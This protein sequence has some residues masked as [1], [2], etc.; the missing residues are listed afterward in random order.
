MK[1]GVERR[2]ERSEYTKEDEEK[3]RKEG[4][5]EEKGR[6]RRKSRRA[7]KE[8]ENRDGSQEKL[9]AQSEEESHCSRHRKPGITRVGSDAEW[10]FHMD[11]HLGENHSRIHTVAD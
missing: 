2:E 9:R 8:L 5:K 6:E 1:K 11:P 4:K 3:K 7:I 10:E